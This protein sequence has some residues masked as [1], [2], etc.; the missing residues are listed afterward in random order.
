M[1]PRIPKILILLALLGILSSCTSVSYER[2]AP[3]GT[4]TKFR[5]YAPM[6]N[7]EVLNG[8]AVDSSSKLSTNGLRLTS[9]SSEPNAAAIT[10]SG[11]ALGQLIGAAAK[12]AA[13]AP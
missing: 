12:T 2:T 13:G 11:A 3:D 4:I 10:A 5:A 6:F 1:K 8:L 7:N 9:T